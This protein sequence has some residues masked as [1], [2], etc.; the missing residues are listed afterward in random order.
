MFDQGHLEN[1][2]LYSY[3]RKIYEDTIYENCREYLEKLVALLD[4]ENYLR[5]FILMELELSTIF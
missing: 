3:R 4:E 2:V 1:V 5:T